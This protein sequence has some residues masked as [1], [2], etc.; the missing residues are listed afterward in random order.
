LKGLLD[1]SVFV[2]SEQGRPLSAL[3]DEVAISVVTLAELHVGVL[4][5]SDHR[6]RA[7]RLRTLA[8]VERTFDPLP[9]DADVARRF[10]ELV[11][12]SRRHGRRPKI[13]DALIAGTALRHGL[14][15]YTQDEDFGQFAGV[16]VVRI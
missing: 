13:L 10:A 14:T 3:P 1:T 8:E 9:V 12:D 2:A 7:Q 15:V 4:V 5:A 11:A 6:I 16:K